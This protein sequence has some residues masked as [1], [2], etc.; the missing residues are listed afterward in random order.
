MDRIDLHIEADN[1]TYG[2]LS[3]T[4]NEEPS[5]TIKTR[6]EAAREIQRARFADA[7]NVHC[8]AKMS[9]PMVKKYCALDAAGERVM[10]D[11]FEKLQ[12]SA[13]AYSRILKVARTIADLDATAEIQ[14][15]HIIEAV[16]YR[17]LDRK[18]G[19]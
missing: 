9:A 16:G 8:N 17:T 3:S 7:E 15:A 2:D 19:V 14:P 18:Y 11:A 4:A 5:A 12:L 13:R 1:V 6:V 10:R